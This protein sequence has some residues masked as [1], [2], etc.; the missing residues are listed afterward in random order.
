MQLFEYFRVLNFIDEFNSIADDVIKLKR[1]FNFRRV[2]EY[3][4][5]QRHHFKSLAINRTI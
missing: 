4:S 5:Y 1:S 2:E 3:R